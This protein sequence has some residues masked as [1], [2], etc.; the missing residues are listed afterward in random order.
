MLTALDTL[1]LMIT[2]GISLVY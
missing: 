2:K 1:R